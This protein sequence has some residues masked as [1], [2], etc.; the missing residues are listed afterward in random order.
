MIFED[1]LGVTQKSCFSLYFGK[2]SNLRKYCSKVQ[3]YTKNNLSKLFFDEI[4]DFWWFFGKRGAPKKLVFHY[5]K[6]ILQKK[7]SII[8]YLNN[9]TKFKTVPK[10]TCLSSFLMKLYDFWGFF[11]NKGVTKKNYFSLFLS[12]FCQKKNLS[13]FT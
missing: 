5:F 11:G 9:V 8:I 4:R 13:S 2:F 6:Q 7:K 12:K 3:N 1:F 10:F